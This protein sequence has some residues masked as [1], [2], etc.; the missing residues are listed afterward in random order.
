ML[1]YLGISLTG[2]LALEDAELSE[3]STDALG[4]DGISVE[5]VF[6]D[7]AGDDDDGD[8]LDGAN[9]LKLQLQMD[10]THFQHELQKSL[11][12]VQK[13]IVATAAET[14][15]VPDRDIS[16]D[17]A[18]AHIVDELR[19]FAGGADEPAQTFD[20]VGPEDFLARICRKK[21][22]GGWGGSTNSIATSRVR[23]A[24]SLFE[25]QRRSFFIMVHHSQLLFVSAEQKNRNNGSRKSASFCRKELW[26]QV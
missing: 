26:W 14:H 21:S 1:T 15:E 6:A 20:L 19:N 9:D 18:D 7:G 11:P 23:W 22:L 12:A 4:E 13:N 8:G 10:A 5:A 3:L 24:D 25:I 17:I 16:D 2:P